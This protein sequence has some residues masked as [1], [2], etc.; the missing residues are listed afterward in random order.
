M[1]KSVRVTVD[2]YLN[3]CHMFE[4]MAL[5]RGHWIIEHGHTQEEAVGR[6]VRSIQEL[7]NK[8]SRS[9]VELRVVK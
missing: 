4:S 7:D 9:N 2:S 6:V 8:F 3:D 1:S 5:Y